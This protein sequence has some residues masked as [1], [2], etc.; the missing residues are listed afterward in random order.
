MNNHDKRTLEPTKKIYRICKDKEE[1]TVRRQRGAISIKSNPIPARWV[2]HRL[3]I[4]NTKEV[5][6]LL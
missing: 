6:T 2:T 3:E 4:H 5:L 1:A